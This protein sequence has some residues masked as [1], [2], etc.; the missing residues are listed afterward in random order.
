MACAM[1]SS[2]IF[3]Q[4][5]PSFKYQGVARN[6]SNAP[7]VNQNIGLRLSILNAS[8]T[9]VY[10]ETHAPRTSDLGIFSVNVCAGAN[11]TGSCGTIDWSAGQFSL[12][13]EMDPAGGSSYANMGNSPILMAPIAAYALKSGGSSADLDGNPTNELQDLSF[14]D[15]TG[16]LGI[17][18]RNSVN[19]SSLKN[20]ADADPSNEIQNLTLDTSDNSL[21]LSKNGGRVLLPGG[22]GL[23][24]KAGDSLVYKHTSSVGI[25]FKP[26]KLDFK[27]GPD[28]YQRYTSSTNKYS[29]EFRSY[30][31]TN[32]QKALAIGSEIIEYPVALNRL[33]LR[34]DSDTFYRV[35]STNWSFAPGTSPGT[36]TQD[37]IFS[38]ANNNG[39]PIRTLS[40]RLEGSGG[41]GNMH[42]ALGGRVTATTGNL[43]INN[44]LTPFVGIWNAQGNGIYGLFYNAQGQANLIAQVKNFVE[45]H[46]TNPNKQIWYTCMEGPEVAA[47]ER[48]SATLKNGETEILFSEHFS[49]LINPNTI[50]VQLSPN[51]AE[52]EGLAVIE[53]TARGFKVKELRKGTGNYS[54]DWEVKAVRKGYENFEVVRDRMNVKMP[55]NEVIDVNQA[56]PYDKSTLKK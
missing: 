22:A 18:Q 52:S 46:P 6:A 32:A 7:L 43:G 12:K 48:G 17:S 10:V 38:Q 30:L 47:Y 2:S 50:T 14:S 35:N 29:Q 40:T 51:S 53:K 31:A 9:P 13:V 4:V 36:I 5:S 21:I 55:T 23:W 11:P 45:D 16:I 3:A 54:F 39:Q 15:A 20:D 27:F 37:E 56:L 44:V 49:V 26:N 28:I 34:F 41:I 19:L 8:G 1:I 33:Y 24:N 25:V 42:A